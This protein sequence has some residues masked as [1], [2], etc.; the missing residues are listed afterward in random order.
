MFDRHYHYIMKRLIWKGYTFTSIHSF[1]STSVLF[2]WFSASFN[3][4]SK[5]EMI[6]HKIIYICLNIFLCGSWCYCL[7]STLLRTI[8]DMLFCF[9][10]RCSVWCLGWSS[11]IFSKYR[12]TLGHLRHHWNSFI[13]IRYNRIIFFGAK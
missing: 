3:F 2:V 13:S 1:W 12:L 7:N 10:D 6:W 5:M 11:L 4:A 8:Q 9:F